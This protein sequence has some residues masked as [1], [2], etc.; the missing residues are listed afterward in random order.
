MRRIRPKRRRR[1]SNRRITLNSHRISLISP[2]LRLIPTCR[3]HL[4]ICPRPLPSLHNHR[5]LRQLLGNR[6]QQRRL[7]PQPRLGPRLCAHHCLH[8]FTLSPLRLLLSRPSRFTLHILRPSHKH[9]RYKSEVPVRPLALLLP[10]LTTYLPQQ[11]HITSPIGRLLRL[12][13]LHRLLQHR[14]RRC[15]DAQLQRPLY[16]LLRFHIHRYHLVLIER[17]LK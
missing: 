3:L 2:H 6:T 9:R 12:P 1:A 8:T 4:R 17:M 13:M 15:Q 5:T 10:L 7:L 16:P 11:R 14:N